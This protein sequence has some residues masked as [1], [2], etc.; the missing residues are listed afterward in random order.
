MF[1]RSLYDDSQSIS[2]WE[3]LLL[4]LREIFILQ[5]SLRILSLRE[6]QTVR[7]SLNI[8]LTH[9]RNQMFKLGH[10]S[11]TSANSVIWNKSLKLQSFSF[12]ISKV[13]WK[14]KMALRLLLVLKLYKLGS[15]S[16][17]TNFLGEL[18]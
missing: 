7:E 9:R 2:F 17:P 16:L 4:E 1:W 11:P 8:S 6:F 3:K 14:N 10:Y 12:F 15:T 13:R 5:A 18:C